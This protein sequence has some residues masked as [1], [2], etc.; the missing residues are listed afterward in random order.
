MIEAILVLQ[1]LVI[2]TFAWWMVKRDRR[3]KK[4]ENRLHAAA[5]YMRSANASHRGDINALNV[6]VRNLMRGECE[7]REL[8]IKAVDD[9]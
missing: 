2:F 1:V 7:V 6:M 5:M 9:G 4:L 8:N 3:L